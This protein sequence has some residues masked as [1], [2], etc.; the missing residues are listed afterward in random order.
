MEDF[1]PGGSSR[2]KRANQMATPFWSDHFDRIQRQRRNHLPGIARPRVFPIVTIRSRRRS[3]DWGRIDC[4]CKRTESRGPIDPVARFWKRRHRSRWA[5]TRGIGAD[6]YYDRRVHV[7]AIARSQFI[8]SITAKEGAEPV[9][10]EAEFR[11]QLELPAKAQR[12][13]K[14]RYA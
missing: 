7:P 9:L 14:S 6:G 8:F 11:T 3:S 10:I 5:C 13:L 4:Y 2:P 12:G 1:R